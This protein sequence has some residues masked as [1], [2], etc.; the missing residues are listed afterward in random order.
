MTAKMGIKKYG[1]MAELKLLAEFQ[2][3]MEY[4]T[5]HRVYASKLT[6]QQK[7]RAANMINLIEEKINR[8]HTKDNPVIKGRSVFNGRIQR[9]LYSKEDTASPTASQD[10]FFLT[11]IIDAIEGRK[12][13]ITDIKGAYLNAK[14]KHEVFMKISGP[15]IDLFCELDPTLRKFITVEKG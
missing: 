4:K 1:R 14:M 2:H 3:L 9:G 6:P 11:S 12:T 8:G 10:A 5:F 13:A 15:E 7:K